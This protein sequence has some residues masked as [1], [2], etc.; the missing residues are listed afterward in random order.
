MP[1]VQPVVRYLILCEDVQ[2]GP[3]NP[4]QVTLVRLVSTIR[5]QE[6]PPFPLRHGELC[7][8]IQL[9]DCRGA[10]DVRVE[11]VSEDTGQVIFRTRAR[12]VTFKGDP[13]EVLGLTFRIRGC[14]F[15]AAG[16]YRVE[17]WYNGAALAQ[18]PL[19]VR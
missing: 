15:P 4:D 14:T 1:G 7:V 16:L 18:Q 8:F 19:L 3:A 11:I 17:F 9:T 12:R 6:Q 5:S 2:Y 10:G 13:L